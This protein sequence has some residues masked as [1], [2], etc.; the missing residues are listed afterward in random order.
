MAYKYQPIK[1]EIFASDGEGDEVEDLEEGEA[2]EG[3]TILS[4]LE[5]VEGVAQLPPNAKVKQ[6]IEQ[7]GVLILETVEADPNDPDALPAGATLL[8][9]GAGGT[10]IAEAENGAIGAAIIDT[11][12]AAIIDTNGTAIIDTNGTAIIDTNGATII[13]TNGAA[14]LSNGHDSTL[15]TT[16][17]DSSMDDSAILAEL[18]E[19][20]VDVKPSPSKKNKDILEQ[21]EKVQ[22]QLC[23]Q[24]FPAGNLRWHIL[25][26]HCH[27]KVRTSIKRFSIVLIFFP[28]VTECSLCEQ[29]FVTKNALKNHIRQVHLSETSTCHICHKEYKDLYHHVKY[30]HEKIRN[31]ECSYCEK[32]FQAKKL[33]YNHVQSIHLGEKTNCPDCGKD[34]SVDNFSRHVRETHERV[35]KYIFFLRGNSSSVQCIITTLNRVAAISGF[36]YFS[37][38]NN[39]TKHSNACYGLLYLYIYIGA[40]QVNVV[41]L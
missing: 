2:E 25:K 13:D 6:V 33:L 30:F 3:E 27:N 15:D 11:N 24:S 40:T 17:G 21:G 36:V 29:K 19:A 10:I 23:N 9:D 28:Q 32:K 14:I 26:E 37:E 12:G 34:I 39:K 22:C 16:N 35:I 5:N 4:S 20:N 8:A 38:E 7:D 18:E 31:Y 41:R 1:D